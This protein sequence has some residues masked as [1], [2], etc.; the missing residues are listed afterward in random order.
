[1]SQTALAPSG[2]LETD[3]DNSLTEA[4]TEIAHQPVSLRAAMKDRVVT[5]LQKPN[6][7]NPKRQEMI[8]A[9]VAIEKASPAHKANLLADYFRGMLKQS[10]AQL[11]ELRASKQVDVQAARDKIE[12][13]TSRMMEEIGSLE[14]QKQRLQGAIEETRDEGKQLIAAIEHAAQSQIEAQKTIC[15]SL[16]ASLVP[17]DKLG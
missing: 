4:M 11:S 1:M 3:L 5:P 14:K 13:Q 16:K 9:Q 8:D 15:E 10:E 17:F 2:D 7:I 6:A 12:A